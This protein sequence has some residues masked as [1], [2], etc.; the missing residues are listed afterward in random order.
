MSQAFGD[1]YAIQRL[2][3]G[4]ALTAPAEFKKINQKGRWE[5]TEVQSSRPFAEVQHQKELPISGE[6]EAPLCH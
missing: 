3:S 1:I 4:G 5:S 2:R 6:S